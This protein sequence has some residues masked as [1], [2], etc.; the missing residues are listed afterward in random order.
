LSHHHNIILKQNAKPDIV[1]KSQFG[2]KKKGG[3]KKEKNDAN[4]FDE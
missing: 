4:V 1:N 3:K 2:Y